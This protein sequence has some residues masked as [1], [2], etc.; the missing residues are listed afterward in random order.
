[1]NEVNQYYEFDRYRDAQL[2]VTIARDLGNQLCRTVS[3]TWLD[4]HWESEIAPQVIKIIWGYRR[5]FAVVAA[6]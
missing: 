4:E 3:R 5:K 2:A 1:M 6:S